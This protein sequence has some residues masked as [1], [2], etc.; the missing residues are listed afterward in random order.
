MFQKH[1]NATSAITGTMRFGASAAASRASGTAAN[2]SRSTFEPRSLGT[3]NATTSAIEEDRE[4][5]EQPPS[6][7]HARGH[8]DPEHPEDG[9]RDE[10]GER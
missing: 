8:G 3:T 2:F 7:G 9:T 5:A 6:A 1:A 4:E 10:I